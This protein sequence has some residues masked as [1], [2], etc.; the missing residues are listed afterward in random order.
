MSVES[1]SLQSVSDFEK[2]GSPSAAESEVR[3]RRKGFGPP[4]AR[5][6]DNQFA[7]PKAEKGWV[8]EWQAPEGRPR[9]PPLS[10]WSDLGSSTSLPSM[11]SPVRLAL[12]DLPGQLA[13]EAPRHAPGQGKQLALPPG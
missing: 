1:A 3:A 8:T 9:P 4:T 13:L 2:L 7:V 5:M 11:G 6:L 12:G 10:A